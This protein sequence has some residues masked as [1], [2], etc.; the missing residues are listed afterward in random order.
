[1]VQT[2]SIFLG[3]VPRAAIEPGPERA[4][5][6]IRGC[7]HPACRPLPRVA[8]AQIFCRRAWCRAGHGA[9]YPTIHGAGDRV[10]SGLNP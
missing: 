1:M 8:G 4:H 10:S 2:G 5:G 3:Q 9:V 6:R 7:R